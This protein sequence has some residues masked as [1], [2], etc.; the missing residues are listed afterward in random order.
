M[1][2]H[3]KDFPRPLQLGNEYPN[4]SATS[5]VGKGGAMSENTWESRGSMV[6]VTATVLLEV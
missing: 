2:P 6:T 5:A 1:H 3:L 4:T